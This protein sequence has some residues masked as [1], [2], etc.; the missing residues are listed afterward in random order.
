MNCRVFAKILWASID[1][2]RWLLEGK[3]SH[4][5]QIRHFSRAWRVA[6]V[7]VSEMN[8]ANKIFW[9]GMCSREH[10]NGSKGQQHR[11]VTGSSFRVEGPWEAPAYL[12]QPPAQSLASSGPGGSRFCSVRSWKPPWRLHSLSVPP[13]PLLDWLHGRKVFHDF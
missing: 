6:R 9:A 13:L 7:R 10:S 2:S 5:C 8:R 3:K 4:W 11:A 12:V 1:W